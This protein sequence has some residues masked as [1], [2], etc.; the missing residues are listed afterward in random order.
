MEP[1]AIWRRTL[2]PDDRARTN[3][4]LA[5]SL[6]GGKPFQAEFRIVRDDGSVRHLRGAAHVVRDAHGRALR[7]IGLNHDVTEQRVLEQELREQNAL[8]RNILEALPCGMSVFDKNLDLVASNREYRRLLDFPAQLFERQPPRFEDFIRYN[9]ER[10]EYGPGDVDAIVADIVQ[11]ARGEPRAHRFERVRPG[12][13][14]LEIQ[15]APMPGGGFVT[16][17]ID[18]SERKAAEQAIAQKE[19]LLRGAIDT[20]NIKAGMAFEAAVAQRRSQRGPARLVGLSMRTS[21]SAM[22][23]SEC[24]RR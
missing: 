13:I 6:A 11:R 17:Y 21:P 14:P 9:A 24:R 12:G 23:N 10:G 7:M 8:M 15:G 5:T 18:I 4:A 16:T 22:E 2:H 3:D 1:L 20:V 19:A